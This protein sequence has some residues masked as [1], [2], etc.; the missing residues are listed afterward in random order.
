MKAKIVAIDRGTRKPTTMDPIRNDAGRRLVAA[1]LS[2]VAG[3]SSID[4]TMRKYVPATVAPSWVLIAED[5]IAELM[6]STRMSQKGGRNVPAKP[7]N[8]QERIEP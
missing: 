4:Y 6:A 8:P 1:L 7:Q 5:L 2:Y 3:H